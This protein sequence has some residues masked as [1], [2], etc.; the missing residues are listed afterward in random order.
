MGD[1]RVT[2]DAVGGHGCQRDV[3]EGGTVVGCG[4]STCPDCITAR[5]IAE[6]SKAGVHVKNAKIQHWPDTTGEVIDA[7]DMSVHG[8]TLQPRIRSGNF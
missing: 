5:Y 4:G 3:P 8:L 7:F 6:M 1:F 2:V